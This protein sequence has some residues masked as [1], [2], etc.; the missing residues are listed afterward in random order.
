M[1]ALRLE[2]VRHAGGLE[3][4]RGDVEGAHVGEDAGDIDGRGRAGLGRRHAA[5]SNLEGVMAP[6]TVVF[7]PANSAGDRMTMSEASA[8]VTLTAPRSAGARP[9]IWN[10][11]SA[12]SAPDAVAHAD[13]P[14]LWPHSPPRRKAGG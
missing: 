12:R 2:L 8:V 9:V 5:R 3:H 14:R 1:A 10:S 13:G 11:T 7:D 6:S 4:G